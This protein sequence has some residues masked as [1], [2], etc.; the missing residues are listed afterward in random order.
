MMAQGAQSYTELSE[1]RTACKKDL[2]V[3]P[4]DGMGELARGG[5]TWGLSPLGW[6]EFLEAERA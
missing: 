1:L 6:T 2:Q 3:L 5:W 4:T